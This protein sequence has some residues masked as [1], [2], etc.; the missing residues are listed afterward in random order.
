MNIDHYVYTYLKI[1]S[2]KFIT[3]LKSMKVKFSS[4]NGIKFSIFESAPKFFLR[5]STARFIFNVWIKK[6]VEI[7]K[8]FIRLTIKFG[9]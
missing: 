5:E 8:A 2:P 4:I 3:V 7:F 6:W 9:L 1:T